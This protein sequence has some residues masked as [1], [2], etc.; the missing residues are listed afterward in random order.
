[1]FAYLAQGD[2]H[3]GLYASIGDYLQAS[4]DINNNADSYFKCIDRIRAWGGEDIPIV[5]VMGNHEN[6][7]TGVGELNGGQA[8]E[9]VVGNNNYGLVAR[10]V[11]AQDPD[12][13]IYYVVAFGCAHEK[14]IDAAG[15]RAGA[16]NKYWVNPDAI[17]ALDET[18]AEIYGE[19]NLKNQG[20][21][22]FIDAHIPVHYFTS[23]RSAENNCDLLSV[24]NKYPNVVYIWGHNHSEKDPAYGT[25]RLPGNTI[26]PNAGLDEL[27]SADEPA[28]QEI[29]FTY[30]SCGAVRG[31]QISDNSLESSERALYVV[32]DGSVLNFEYC[33]R[34][35]E[36]FDRTKYSD[37]KD[38]TY[39]EDFKTLEAESA[40]GITVDLAEETRED[41]VL[42]GDFFLTRPIAGQTPG[43]VLSFSDRYETGI[44][45]FDAEGNPAD[46]EFAYGEEYTARLM[47]SSD[48]V[49]FDLTENDVYLF[50]MSA[51]AIPEY[52]I[53]GKTV[54]ASDGRAVIDIV[55]ESTAVLADE[56]LI[57]ADELQ[58]G[59]RYV[60]ASDREQYLFT[61]SRMDC[62]AED[63]MLLTVP[64]A[65]AYWT[66][67]KYGDG[68]AMRNANGQYLT[69]GVNGPHVVLTPVNSPE[70]G[71]YAQWN[72]RDGMLTIDMSG[73]EYDFTYW[74]GAFMLYSGIDDTTCRLYELPT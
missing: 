64:D 35:G 49:S 40:A 36:L 20:I 23:E 24:L 43:S 5:S 28:A 62:V 46:G 30:I 50:D 52:Y 42:R 32:T 11:D 22:T 13:T 2:K 65:D 7:T 17:A 33:G 27:N 14:E 9:K 4:S 15:T 74:N 48:D 26:V 54:T 19:D 21:P 59:K 61:H 8:F 39:F 55:F 16:Q 66:F 41:V 45:W 69:A 6:K 34:E 10:G 58:E 71:V 70:E 3:P 47:L 72:I 63:G 12:K 60:L 56:P 51:V 29:R 18:L 67:E 38:A 1:M 68:Y 57:A 31:N 53:A 25:I 44:Q 73:T 37:L